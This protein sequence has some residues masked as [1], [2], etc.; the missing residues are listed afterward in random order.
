[1]T[2]NINRNQ[3]LRETAAKTAL[4]EHFGDIMGFLK[5]ENESF[6]KSTVIDIYVEVLIRRRY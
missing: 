2:G 1:M 3:T 5:R 6:L 4:N